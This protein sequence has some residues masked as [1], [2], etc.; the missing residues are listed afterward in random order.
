[1]RDAK[2]FYFDEYLKKAPFSL[3]LWR[4]IEAGEV[5]KIKY[6]RPILDVGCGF[7]EFAGVCFKRKVEVGIDISPRDLIM[8]KEGGKYKKLL[9]ADTRKLPFPKE[10][11][12]TVISI[13]VLEHVPDVQLA[14]KEIF[15]VLKKDGLLIFTVPTNRLYN[16]LFYP[17]LLEKLNLSF[18]AKGYYRL[19]NKAFK[20]VN[21]VDQNEWIKMAQ[22]AGFTVKLLKEIIPPKATMIFDIFLLSAFPSQLGRTVFGKRFVW[23]LRSKNWLLKKLFTEVLLEENKIGSNILLVAQKN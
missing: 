16:C 13:S 12:S 15:R 23:G 21:I 6:K 10:S 14:I 7:G 1:M 4:A 5:N 22:K 20:H 11:F 2:L 9:L 17:G 8:A 18:L 19:Y 3:A